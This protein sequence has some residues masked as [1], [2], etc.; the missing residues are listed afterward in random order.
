MNR[1]T[2]GKAHLIC[3]L[4]IKTIERQLKCYSWVACLNNAD[5]F[6]PFQASVSCMSA[7]ESV[8]TEMY[9]GIPLNEICLKDRF[10][11]AWDYISKKYLRGWMHGRYSIQISSQWSFWQ[12]KLPCQNVPFLL[13]AT[14]LV[15]NGIYQAKFLPMLCMLNLP[16]YMQEL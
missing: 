3:S 5:P 1:F 6:E 16:Y 7:S 13:Q 10:T 2:S 4:Y 14:I 15:R 12:K 9:G 11:W 8:V